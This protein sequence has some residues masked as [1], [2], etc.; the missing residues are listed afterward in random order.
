LKEQINRDKQFSNGLLKGSRN[1]LLTSPLIFLQWR[2]I[3]NEGYFLK[4]NVV[5]AL[6]L[7]QQIA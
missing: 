6:G 3:K 4:D 1:I 7:L 5:A 2:L